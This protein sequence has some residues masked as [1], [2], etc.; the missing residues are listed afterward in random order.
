MAPAEI[1]KKI[2]VKGVD[3]IVLS[4]CVQMPSLAAIQAVEDRY[5]L[6][7]VSSSICTTHQML[8]K[9][10]LKTFV[11]KAGSLLSGKY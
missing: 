9:L 8:K 6:P 1:V 4:V 10:G 3:A 5:G 7:V 2:N 11:P